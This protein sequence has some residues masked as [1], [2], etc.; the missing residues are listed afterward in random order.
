MTDYQD[1]LLKK[2]TSVQASGFT[3][4]PDE[5]S[6]LLYPYQRKV[7]EGVYALSRR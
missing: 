1:F 2:V 4:A 5:V 7:V 3:V 6:P